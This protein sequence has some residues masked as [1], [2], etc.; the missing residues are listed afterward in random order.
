MIVGNIVNCNTDIGEFFNCLTIDEFLSKET[1]LPT[2][3]IG[4]D[5]V[6]TKL[7]GSILN[8]TI[9]PHGKDGL[10]GV[11]WTFAP[12]EKRGIY[13]DDLKSFKEKCYQDLI[14][15]VKTY[16]IDP[17]IY[18]IYT[19][20]ELCDKINKLSEGYGYLYQDRIVYVYKDSG[21]YMFDLEL[22]RFIGF[23]VDEIITTFKKSLVLFSDSLE[24]NFKEELKHI[25][26]K[27]VPFLEYKNA[28][29]NTFIS[30]IHQQT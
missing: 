5:V 13:E 25:D 10:P 3:V 7:K 20:T 6:K 27:Y 29:Q 9:H 14:K 15:D 18:K 30:N 24:V 2:L 19:T 22:Y 23:D 12:T 21:I 16:N 28:T 4:W 8:K 11:Y 17:I 1:T 26:I